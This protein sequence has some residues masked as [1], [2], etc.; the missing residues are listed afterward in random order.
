MRIGGSTATNGSEGG[1]SSS[2]VVSLVSVQAVVEGSSR[3]GGK[4]RPHEEST[5][6]RV[7]PSP[8]SWDGF[9]QWIAGSRGR[10]S[11]SSRDRESRGW[12]WLW[13]ATVGRA[14]SLLGNEDHDDSLLFIGTR[15]PSSYT[16]RHGFSQDYL[17]HYAKESS[18]DV[19][20]LER[21]TS[22]ASS[23]DLNLGEMVSD[24]AIPNVVP[25]VVTN[26]AGSITNAAGAVGS[27]ASSAGSTATGAVAKAVA[28][29]ITTLANGTQAIG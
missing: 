17:L 24:L 9:T 8:E 15:S 16:R 19:S 14:L 4:N 11:E 26:A 29:P 28:N 5:I 13:D 21:T 6:H 12:G 23:T 3:S 22:S 20:P 18:P 7:N 27:A 25:D 10:G 1:N 2:T